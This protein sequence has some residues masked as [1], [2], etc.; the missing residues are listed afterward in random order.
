MFDKL[1][2]E[3]ITLRPLEIRTFI[4]TN[5]RFSDECKNVKDVV[6]NNQGISYKLDI[7]K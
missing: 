3:N 7:E 5:L 1:F 4:L 6:Y 2:K